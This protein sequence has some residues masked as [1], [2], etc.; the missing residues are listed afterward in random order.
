MRNLCD[1]HDVTIKLISFLAV[2]LIGTTS[3]TP[4]PCAI[5]KAAVRDPPVDAVR[6]N[7]WSRE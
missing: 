2:S 1:G 3:I 6:V 4:D 7:P 5:R